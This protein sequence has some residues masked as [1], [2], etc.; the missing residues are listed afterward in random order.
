MKQE[1]GK[2]S[3][4][5]FVIMGAGNIAGKFVDAVSRIDGC[6]VVA[7]ASKSLEKAQAFAERNGIPAAY[8]SYEEMLIREKADGVYIANT[9]ESH[10]PLTMLSLQ[11]G[12]HVLCEKAM[13]LNSTEA[14]TAF[15]TAREK[16]LFLMEGTWSRFLPSNVRAKEWINTC[17]I[18][19][20]TFVEAAIGFRA[21]THPGN[22]YFDR[23]LGGGPARDILI[24]AYELTTFFMGCAG[25]ITHA[26][27]TWS[28]GGVD[29]SNQVHMRFPGALASLYTSF[30]AQMEERIVIHGTDGKIVIPFP[31]YASEAYLYDKNDDLAE[32]FVDTQT[33][34]G[35]TY[36][37]EEMLACIR[38]GRCESDVVP[39]DETIRCS[40]LFDMIEATRPGR[41]A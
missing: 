21:P 22:R 37:I 3:E 24:Y 26:D 13:F 6:C 5:R 19:D 9:P 29:L 23:S 41:D 8:G 40:R 36:E 35:F 2:M 33:E 12:M 34:N 1:E 30:V 4:F 20:V 31:H 18:G 28:E 32:H 15:R 27:A 38:S 14:E 10:F 17:R 25:E 7:V 16:G 11:H 39:H